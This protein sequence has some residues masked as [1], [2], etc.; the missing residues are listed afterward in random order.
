FHSVCLNKSSS[1]NG[2]LAGELTSPLASV[3]IVTGFLEVLAYKNYDGYY[4]GNDNGGSHHSA[5]HPTPTD[6]TSEKP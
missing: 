5:S 4:Y 2:S 3:N 6:K 1:F